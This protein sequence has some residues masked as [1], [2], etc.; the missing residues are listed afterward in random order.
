[1]TASQRVVVA[2]SGGVDSSVAASLLVEQ[3]I[4][5]F[6]LMMRLCRPTRLPEL[7]FF[8]ITSFSTRIKMLS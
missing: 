1:M 8:F 2:M 6:G 7:A 3:G 4:E 5:T